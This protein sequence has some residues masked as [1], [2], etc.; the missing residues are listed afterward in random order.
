MRWEMAKTWTMKRNSQSRLVVLL[1]IM[2]VAK[3][4][5]GTMDTSAA[6]ITKRNTT[7]RITTTT[8]TSIDN[9]YNKMTHKYLVCSCRALRSFLSVDF[10]GWMVAAW[11]RSK[12]NAEVCASSIEDLEGQ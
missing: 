2:V 4:A 3:N 11:N 5:I 9:A 7:S 10:A 6:I 1:V 8:N 12:I